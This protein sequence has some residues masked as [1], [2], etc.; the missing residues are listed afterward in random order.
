MQW[1]VGFN[2]VY[3]LIMWT[4]FSHVCV[5]T[6]SVCVQTLRVCAIGCHFA[7]DIYTQRVNGE[8]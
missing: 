6:F 5:F 3:L 2:T 4:M 1:S 8:F 7:V